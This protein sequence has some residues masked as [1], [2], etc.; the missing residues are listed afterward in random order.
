MALDHTPAAA[1][2]DTQVNI[3]IVVNIKHYFCRYFWLL[4]ISHYMYLTNLGQWK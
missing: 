3:V 1:H 2:L 4:E